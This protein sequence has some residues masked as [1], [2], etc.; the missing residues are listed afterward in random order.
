MSVVFEK[1]VTTKKCMKHDAFIMPADCSTDG[2]EH[3]L[4]GDADE[5]LNHWVLGYTKLPSD[6]TVDFVWLLVGIQILLLGVM[7]AFITGL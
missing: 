3:C 6:Y 1:P 7:L 4:S 5:C 2:D